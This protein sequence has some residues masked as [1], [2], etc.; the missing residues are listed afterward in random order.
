MV[1]L[2]DIRIDMRD[3]DRLVRAMHGQVPARLQQAIIGTINRTGRQ[4]FTQVRRNLSRETG[5]PQHDLGNRSRA[6]R[7]KR[8]RT[9]DISYEI[10]VRGQY[11]PLSY[12][13]P[14]QRLKGVSA[15]PWGKRRIF[16]G[17]FLATMKSGHVGVFK[18]VKGARKIKELWGPALPVELGRGQSGPIFA[19]TFNTA[20]GPNLTREVNRVL[21]ML[22]R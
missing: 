1:A 6:L 7:E 22:K 5:I 10:L 8:A 18:R 17:T 4:G 13:A 16:R 11:T 2:P 21:D 19:D 14:A 9:G 20:I 15:R 3:V 12:F